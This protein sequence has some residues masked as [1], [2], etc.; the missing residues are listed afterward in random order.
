MSGISE[1]TPTP[2]IPELP[3]NASVEERDA[4]W[5][6]YI[7]RADKEPQ[8]TLRA[9][10]FGGLI[11]IL[12]CASSMY[13]SL[14]IGW[15]F[16][17]NI[18]ACIISFVTF[19]ALRNLSRGRIKSMGVLENSATASVA[20]VTGQTPAHTVVGAFGG[21]VLL[22]AT[23][24]GITDGIVPWYYMVPTVF[25]AALLG[26]LV[27]IPLKRTVINIEQLKFP[28][29]IAFAETMKTLYA[30]GNEA[31]QKARCLLAAMSIGAFLGIW[32]SLPKL[33]ELLKD[34]FEL[35]WLD[36]FATK[37]ALPHLIEFKGILNPL[38]W[39]Q[40]D[41][42]RPVL[43][44]FDISLLLVG[45]GMIVGL[46]VS[47]SMLGTALLLNC[48]I[49]PLLVKQ[50]L[51][52]GGITEWTLAMGDAL[53]LPIGQDLANTYN[54]IGIPTWTANLEFSKDASG[55]YTYLIY[56]WSLWCG[57]AVMVMSGISAL[58]LQW[59]ILVRAFKGIFF[60]KTP[61]TK[62]NPV[63]DLE[64]PMKWFAMGIVPVGLGLI[65]TLWLAFDIAP[66]L[67]LVAVLLSFVT[68]LICTRTAGEADVNPIGAMGKV[69]QLL[70]SVLP[71][72][73]GNASINLMT[74]GV[75]ATA[76]GAAADLSSD[77]KV[78][79]LLGLNPRKQFFAQIIG[80]CIGTA[81]VVPIWTLLVPDRETL[82]GYNPPAATMWSAVAKF[83]TDANN[84]LPQSAK[85]AMVI[86]A[87][88]GT[89]MPI[90]EKLV[91]KYRKY[92]PSAMGVGLAMVLPSN[93]PNSLSF[94][95]GAVIMWL[96][97]RARAK[98]CDKYGVP[99]ASGFVA[100]ESLAMAGMAISATIIKN[101]TGFSGWINSFFS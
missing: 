64:V 99:L 2:S 54:S 61:D 33:G 67:G 80:V 1:P 24:S 16:G 93:I 51:A 101:W 7:Y 55:M 96:W 74:A 65:I 72:A 45:A 27:A 63:A 29:S 26:T 81:I 5:R 94:S 56:K 41:N 40:I 49:L 73:K 11:G 38:T 10:A 9:S 37:T 8:L 28:S 36:D 82:L 91:P 69:A 77:M 52:S 32:K 34:N 46:R 86:G 95:L 18:T 76:G 83:L 39:W 89:A 92:M 100:G 60:K 20:V 42:G 88:F 75:T 13:T 35:V 50:D 57:T 68:G 6:K 66:Y 70:Y 17:V 71:G 79:Y 30:H 19:N 4:H 87:I 90:I 78:G 25:F 48:V 3:S 58:M 15:G 85:L 62:I 43:Y 97:Y 84:A 31:V 23:Q 47:L 44:G 22:G 98:N 14:T 53:N 12:A 21:L 59:P